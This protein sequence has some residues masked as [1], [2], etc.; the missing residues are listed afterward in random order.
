LSAQIVL[1]GVVVSMSQIMANGGG[2]ADTYFALAGIAAVGVFLIPVAAL[3][4]YL[5]GRRLVSFVGLVSWPAALPAT[6]MAL[7][8]IGQYEIQSYTLAAAGLAVVMTGAIRLA[9]PSSWWA[10]TRYGR[11]KMERS[12]GRYARRS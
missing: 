6:G 1:G 4:S 7:P 11:T 12:I 3:I 8:L 2:V 9:P 5:K 10:Q